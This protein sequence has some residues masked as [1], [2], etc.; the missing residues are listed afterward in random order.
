MTRRQWLRAGGGMVAVLAV[1]TY[2]VA[3]QSRL[4]QQE[5]AYQSTPKGVQMCGTCTLFV[6]PHGC[7]MVEGTIDRLG[8]CRL[9]DMAD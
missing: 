7:K 8:W 6:R 3:A 5:A 9:Y 4:S 2:P 1:R